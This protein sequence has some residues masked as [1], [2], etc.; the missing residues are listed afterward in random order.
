MLPRAQLSLP[1]PPSL[2]IKLLG[3]PSIV[4]NGKATPG[5]RGRKSWAVI[6]RI[7]LGD[8][9]LARGELVGL[10]FQDAVDP[11]GALRWSLS[12]ARRCMHRDDLLC[13]DPLALHESDA[14]IDVHALAGTTA[15]A[16][17]VAETAGELLAGWTFPACSE[18]EAWLEV[19]RRRAQS[20]VEAHLRD[21]A[22]QH[23]A[24]GEA[25]IAVRLAGQAVA[26]NPLDEALQELLVRCLARHGDRAVFRA[27]S[28]L[29]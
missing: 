28:Q 18:F 9:P 7:S 20:R 5:P 8:R 15:D 13:G 19:E 6:A 25:S 10:L 14:M 2:E 11:L 17:R 22:M 26:A 1:M 29:C 4:L 23:L 12:E 3:S 24:A 27:S 16:L 21:A